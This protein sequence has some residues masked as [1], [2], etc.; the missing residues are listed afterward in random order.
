MSNW[1]TESSE[2]VYETPWFKIHKDSV[3]NH[4]GKLLT[5][6]YM[7]LHHPTVLIVAADA[8]GKVLLQRNYRYPIDR[9]IWEMPAGHSDG[10]EPL[11]AAKRELLEEAGLSST[12]W[13]DLG[14]F[15]TATGTAKMERQ[16]FLARDVQPAASK[17]DEDEEITD[18]TFFTVQEID[19]MIRAGQIESSGIISALYVAKNYGL[20][21]EK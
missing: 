11:E 5:Y 18:Q 15:Y 19:D 4:N 20:K 2:I 8:E 9:T 21:K 17:R 14:H 13:H 16:V 6:S 3:R 1:T 12:D 7:E 10:Q